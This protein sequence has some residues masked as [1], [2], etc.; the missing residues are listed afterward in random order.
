MR[1]YVLRL[2]L[3][4]GSHFDFG[5]DPKTAVE[6]TQCV[7]RMRAILIRRK[8]SLA[9]AE[10][11]I[12][13]TL[14]IAADHQLS[15]LRFKQQQKMEDHSQQA[16]DQLIS[17]LNKLR[18]QISHLPPHSLAVL[19]RRLMAVSEQ[20]IFDTEAFIEVLDAAAKAL[21]QVSPRRIADDAYSM[22][23]PPL[24]ESWFTETNRSPLVDLWEAIPA[25]TRIEVE[26]LM[27]DRQPKISFVAWLDT[28][29]QM[30]D[31][32]RPVR[33]EGAPLSVH[34]I[35][36]FWTARIWKRLGLRVGRTYDVQ[37][38]LFASPNPK[39]PKGG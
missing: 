31:Q 11:A 13:E 22:I 9:A 24:P 8:V 32:K 21:R 17:S 28:L 1:P 10:R 5:S 6:F 39:R 27:Q 20:S 37:K 29:K 34:R 15:H 36:A 30:L 12:G 33:A 14:Q 35:F 18:G 26:R 7:E 4:A 38:S 3:S 23:Y 19:N 25:V 2:R 16:I